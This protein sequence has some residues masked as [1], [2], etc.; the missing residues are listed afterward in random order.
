M[1]LPSNGRGRR[2]ALFCLFAWLALPSLSALPRRLPA[3]E[4]APQPQPDPVTDDDRRFWSFQKV[5]RPDVPQVNDA[6]RVRTPI[7]SFVLARLSAKGLTLSPDADRRTLIRR[8]YLD[9]VGLPPP[10]EVVDAF[11]RD[12]SSDA[13]ER[14]V[15]S[16]LAM[17]QFGERWGRHWLDVAGYVD[18][19]GFDCDPYNIIT[20]DGK[21]QYRDWVIRALNADKPYDQ[22]LVEQLAGDELVDW[23]NAATFTPEIR[24]LLIA[25]GFLRTASDFTHE[26]VGNIPQNHFGIVHDTIEI[27]GTS[28]LG[29]TL[30]CARCHNHKFDPIPTEDYYRLMAAFTPAYNSENWKI[31]FPYDK[32][33]EDRSLADVSPVERAE[34][35]KHNAEI[36]RQIGELTQKLDELRRPYREKL[37]EGKLATVPEP[38]RA[39]TKSAV[40]LPAEKRSEIQKYLAGKFEGQLKVSPEEVAAALSQAD[41]ASA[42]GLGSQVAALNGRRK[43]F[44]KIQALYDVGPPPVTRRL[45]RGNYETP[46]EEVQPGFLRVLC[47]SGAPPLMKA[48]DPPPAGTSGRRLA[49][50]RWLTAPDSRASALAARVM[51]NRVWQHLFG[52]GIVATPEN[53]G[54][55]GA[56]PT[57][58]ELLE[59]LSAEFMQ[60]GWRMK[61]AIRRVV[62]SSVY[63]QSTGALAGDSSSQ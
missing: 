14:L 7:D 8:V 20:S 21:W 55:G 48:A 5:V 63:R 19:V 53:F 46:G 18:T 2:L 49:L 34:I 15:D 47:E 43:S 24:D 56:P 29:L 1:Y 54:P 32:K 25:T 40:D 6:A 45:L 4:A 42:D 27:V 33:L 11:M 17:P 37:L 23:R 58:P 31:V 59:W 26:D 36:E 50:A 30:N 51:V 9:L 41:K 38:I 3:D 52:T 35:E 61:P 22:F 12:E 16:L 39:D 44:G 60:G 13:Y 57:H 10:P 62:C 28:I